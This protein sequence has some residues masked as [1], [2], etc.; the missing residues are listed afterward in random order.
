MGP[1]LPLNKNFEIGNFLQAVMADEQIIIQADG[2]PYRRYPYAA[3]MAA[4]LWVVLIKGQ[5][6]RA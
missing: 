2:T 1:H 6:S 5:S 3:D 4:W